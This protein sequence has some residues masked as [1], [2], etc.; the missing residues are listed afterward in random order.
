MPATGSSYRYRACEAPAAV[1]LHAFFATAG[2]LSE[3]HC[4]FAVDIMGEANRRRSIRVI[5]SGDDYLQWFSE[6]FDGLGLDRMS[7][8]GN[9]MGVRGGVL[10]HAPVGTGAEARSH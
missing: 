3:R 6:L 7:L 1:M 8:V 5:S 9:S 10:C 4:V 2:A